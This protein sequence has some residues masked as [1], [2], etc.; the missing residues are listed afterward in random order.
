MTIDEINQ[1]LHDLH[2]VLAYCSDQQ[3]NGKIYVFQTGE[4]ICINQ[5]R[6]ALLSQLNYN[7]PNDERIYVIPPPIEAK[8]RLILEKIECSAWKAFNQ[9]QFLHDGET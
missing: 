9:N 2:N 5:E 7:F 1:R 6:G 3:N 8:V 4:R